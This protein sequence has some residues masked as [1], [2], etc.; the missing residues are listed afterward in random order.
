MAGGS[1]FPSSATTQTILSSVSSV[2]LGEVGLFCALCQEA[3]LQSFNALCA[4]GSGSYFVK[5]KDPS[6]LCVLRVFLFFYCH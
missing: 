3:L 5:D 2:S 1:A 6:V 4:Q